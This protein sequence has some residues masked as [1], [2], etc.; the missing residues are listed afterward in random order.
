MAGNDI[1]YGHGGDDYLDGGAGDDI[2]WGETG[3]DTL[4]GGDGSD[5]VYYHLSPAAVTINLSTGAASG[6]DAEGDYLTGIEE[7]VGS[8]WNDVLTGDAGVNRLLGSYGDDVL[9]GG[10]GADQLYGHDAGA[11][12]PSGVDRVEYA[13]SLAGVTVNLA[14][15]VNTGGDAQGDELYGIQNLG[16]SDFADSLTGDAG[17]NTLWGHGGNDVVAGGAGN[18]A[19]YG[20]AGAD[21]L[22]GGDG[23]DL[24]I[25]GDGADALNGGAGN[26]TANY[27][28]AGA[29]VTLGLAS[30]GTG[31]VAAGDS[32]TGVENVLGSA[33]DDAIRGDAGANVLRGLVGADR[34]YGGDGADTLTGDAG[35]DSLYGEAGADTL[36]GGDGDDCLT[37]G[38]GAD[39][40]NG[41]N[42]TDIAMYDSAT[43]AVTVNLATGGSAGDATGDTY[44]G[45]E[46]AMGSAYA[47]TITGS[48]G[49]NALWGQAGNDVLNGSGGANALKGGLGADIFVYTA[50]SDSTVAAAGRDS[51]N[52]FSHVEGDRIDLGAI[53]ADGNAGNGDT[54][55][56]F[57]GSGD[58]TG[59][60]HEVRLTFSGGVQIVLADVNGDKV[61]DMAVAVTSATTLVAG[62]FVL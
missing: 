20:E 34:L 23:D 35:N 4:I 6:G 51:I 38:A 8:D 47:D 61:A 13:T 24:L 57:L 27:A 25:G 12:H 41:G 59:A 48:A 33:F 32:F 53:D 62:D 46:N 19:L 14:T 7:V 52:D 3:A 31:G 30:G 28:E 17:A 43:A 44:G 55:F 42:G 22:Q 40:L 56:T 58:F 18:D 11:V 49:V 60:G 1:L 5:M 50:I 54:A 36:Q 15:N 39:A 9:N 29:A 2:L 45:V 37:G 16:G 10:A 21:T 26:D